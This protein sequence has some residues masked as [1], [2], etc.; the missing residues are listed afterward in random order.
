MTPRQAIALKAL[1]RLDSSPRYR[2]G[3][4]LLSPLD[5]PNQ[6]QLMWNIMRTTR[7][8]AFLALSP[9]NLP[10]TLSLEDLDELFDQVEAVIWPSYQKAWLSLLS[11]L[12]ELLSYDQCRR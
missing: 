9:R 8:Q 1:R 5:M 2:N 11:A 7:E 4:A 6:A 10:L 3:I 12:E